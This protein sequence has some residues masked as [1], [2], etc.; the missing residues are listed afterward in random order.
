MMNS[1]KL[2]AVL[3]V[4]GLSFLG[5]QSTGDSTEGEGGGEEACGGNGDD[6]GASTDM[7]DMIIKMYADGTQK[8]APFVVLHEVV[9]T[10]QYWETTS[11]FGGNES[12]NKW[13]VI[14]KIGRSEFIVENDMGMGYIM[15]YQVDSWADQGEPNVEKA[16]IG[17]PG[18][19]AQ[20]IE[21]MEW[22]KGDGGNGEEQAGIV[23]TAEFA[24]VEMAGGTFE[25]D[26][27]TVKND[28][29]ETRT[30]IAGN[31]WFGK[32]IRMDVNDDT[33]MELTGYDFDEKAEGWL[34]WP[35][36]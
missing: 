29:N 16:W 19:E 33:V 6:A 7:A 35:Q 25:G 27:V 31:G 1:I 21:I 11:T 30:W 34:E 5:C 3:I 18:R 17:K 15:A 12:V 22:E 24:D 8:A 20:E 13:Q 9:S 36:D 14:K 10:G 32:V 4:A 2:L 28:G 26:L 23:L